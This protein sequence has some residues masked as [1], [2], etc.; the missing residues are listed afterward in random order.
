MYICNARTR[1]ASQRCSNVRVVFYYIMISH[2]V[3]FGKG[4]TAARDLVSLLQ[5]RGLFVSNT[6]RAEHFL[7]HIGYYRLSAYMYPLLKI[8]KNLHLYKEGATF[9]Q[10]M[11]LYRFDKKLRV[12]LFNELEKIGSSGFWSDKVCHLCLEFEV[13]SHGDTERTED[14]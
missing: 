2:T 12:F 14:Y 10:V 8:P 4:Y 9:E 6:S 11:M 3:P 7:E 1:Q 5:E 13:M